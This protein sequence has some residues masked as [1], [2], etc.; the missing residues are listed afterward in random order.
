MR[1]RCNNRNVPA[2]PMYGG[3][4]IKV[5]ARWDLY[6]NFFADMGSKPSAAHSLDRIDNDK[7]YEPGNCRWATMKEQQRNRRNNRIIEKDGIVATLAAHCERIGVRPSTVLQRLRYGFSMDEALT[8]G[9]L[10]RRTKD[11]LAVTIRRLME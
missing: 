4:G 8:A 9:R 11:A 7:W 10:K 5:C 6:E 2:Y 1:S 3:R